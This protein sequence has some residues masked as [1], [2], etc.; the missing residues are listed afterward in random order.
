MRKIILKNGIKLI[1][2][3]RD[4][5]ISSFCIG[6]DA[7]ALR[8]DGNFLYGTAH[9]LEHMLYKGTKNRSEG[10]INQISDEVFGFSN[11]MTNYPYVIYYGTTLTEN[12]E[13]GLD[14]Y[15]DIV[16]NPDFNVKGFNEEMNI[17]TEE[18]REWVDDPSQLCEDRL[19]WN[20]FKKRRIKER[21]IGSAESIKS[22]NTDHL[23]NFYRRFYHPRNCVVC[24]V[25]PKSFEEIIALAE[26]KFGF[27]GRT[28]EIDFSNSYENNFAGVFVKDKENIEGAKVEY[29]F[30]AHNLNREEEKALILLNFHLGESVTSILYDEIR[31][32]RGLAY[33][34]SSRYRRE[35]GMKLLT[36]SLGT[37]KENTAGTMHLIN[38][39]I[40]EIVH[41]QKYELDQA[42]VT[43]I[44]QMQ[45]IRRELLIEKSIQLAKE[46]CIY[47]IMY[48]SCSEVYSEFDDAGETSLELIKQTAVKVLKV[49]TVQILK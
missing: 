33:D 46:L 18:L 22:I 13:M 38:E 21:I 19:F 9:A 3:K 11:A 29:C 31:T 30:T 39:I 26:K 8:E 1:Y 43:R 4:A 37:S 16:T 44:A 48:G 40:N 32:K 41:G 12:L 28:G 14:L 2:E 23:E 36:I 35:N 42:R 6:F 49:P 45:K 25:T 34:I 24:I 20:S 27:W 5:G 47:E 17:I 7:G 10:E 15:S